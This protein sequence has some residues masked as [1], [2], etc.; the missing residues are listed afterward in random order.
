L[1]AGL[2][3]FFQSHDEALDW[4]CFSAV[5]QVTPSKLPWIFFFSVRL[6]FLPSY[7]PCFLHNSTRYRVC[8]PK[9]HWGCGYWNIS[10][11]GQSGAADL[12]LD[13][14]LD[15]SKLV[16]HHFL[17]HWQYC[18]EF[19]FKS[20][21]WFLLTVAVQPG[22]LEMRRTSHFDL[23]TEGHEGVIQYVA[24]FYHFSISVPWWSLKYTGSQGFP[25]QFMGGSH[26]RLVSFY[27]CVLD[28]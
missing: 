27:P 3:V 18:T 25:T 15:L 20:L 16:T 14:G 8:G 4:T 19:F 10:Y 2:G 24:F 26:C 11:F 22:F 12:C 1:I 23:T 7:I 28:C 13:L 6:V 9:V 17:L 5:W 21:N